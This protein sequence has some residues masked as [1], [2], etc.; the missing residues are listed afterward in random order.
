MSGD[1]AEQRRQE[2]RRDIQAVAA[3][4]DRA[5]FARL[6]G[7]FAPR[8]KSYFIRLG[9]ADAQAE[10]L[11]QEAMLTLWRKAALFDPA[12]A[13][14]AT[15]VFT[16]ARNLRVDQLRRDRP[17]ADPAVLD[18][19]EDDTP[20]AD[21]RLAESQRE[22]SVRAALAALP[23]DQ[24]EVMRLS[25]FEDHPHADIAGRLGIPLGTVKSRLRLAMT[26]V[27]SLLGDEAL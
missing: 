7:Y 22:R 11:A 10:D 6:Y 8:L 3:S 24:A 12:K 14:A 15:W 21:A 5:A 13:E 17:E 20:A 4:G 18:T 19:L 27:R 25:F 9:T 1:E 16:I 26:K 23:P 2:Q